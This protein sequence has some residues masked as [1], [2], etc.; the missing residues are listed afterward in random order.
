MICF[1]PQMKGWE[2]PTLMGPLE[3]TNLSHW[4]EIQI[5]YIIYPANKVVI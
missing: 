1:L 3:R 2:T 5:S 4:T